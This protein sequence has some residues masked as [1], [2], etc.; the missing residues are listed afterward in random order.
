MSHQQT[1]TWVSL[2]AGGTTWKI[3]ADYHNPASGSQ[4]NIYLTDWQ[5]LFSLG[6]MK[7]ADPVP[8]TYAPGRVHRKQAQRDGKEITL[9]VIFGNLYDATA[10]TTKFASFKTFLNNRN[11]TLDTS[12]SAAGLW[13][14]Q[15]VS[16]T[17]TKEEGYILAD[18]RFSLETD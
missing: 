15:Y 8:R 16:L 14:A 2:T 11:F 9:K 5:D 18:L 4:A 10:A 6:E 1:I 17:V 3:A 13:G 7:N 12:N